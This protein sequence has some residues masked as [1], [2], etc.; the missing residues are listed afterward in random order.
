MNVFVPATTADGA[1]TVRLSDD[2]LHRGA[3]KELRRGEHIVFGA[4]PGLI[5]RLIEHKVWKTRTKK[6]KNFGEYAL[7]QTSEGLGIENNQLL[8]LLRCALDVRDK[9]IKEWAEV[10]EEVERS[11]RIWAKEE[12]KS[13]RSFDGNGLEKVGRASGDP[14]TDKKITYLPSGAG[15]SDATLMRLRKNDPKTYQKVISGEMTVSRPYDHDLVLRAMSYIRRMNKADLKRLIGR[16][17]E[18]GLI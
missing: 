1:D 6:F 9:H 12:G 10:L 13:I 2:D 11:V 7:D 8:W 5:D 17:T 14:Q 15:N 18:E 16:M 4:L 3:R